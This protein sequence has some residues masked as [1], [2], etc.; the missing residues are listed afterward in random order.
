MKETKEKSKAKK[1]S[2][3]E[4]ARCGDDNLGINQLAVKGRVLAVLVRGG[5]EGVALVLE[6]LAQ[7]ELILGRP[8]KVRHLLFVAMLANFFLLFVVG[9]F[10]EP[11]RPCPLFFPS[12]SG[13][14][15]GRDAGAGLPPSARP[16]FTPCP[17]LRAEEAAKTDASRCERCERC[18]R[19]VT[20]HTDVPTFPNTLRAALILFQFVNL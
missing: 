1:E 18:D 20:T 9:I 2:S 19:N 17:T 13:C 12:G 14:R 10:A 3:R 4:D 16:A 15:A 6:P 5:H 8:Q 7:A 11:P